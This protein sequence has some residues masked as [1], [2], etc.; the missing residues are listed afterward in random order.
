MKARQPRITLFTTSECNHC[1]QLKQWLKQ[2]RIHFR[3]LN[4]QRSARAMREFR[5]HGGRGL[6]LLLVGERAIRGFD[7]KRLTRELRKAGIDLPG[8]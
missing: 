4:L 2:H 3:E 8:L 6:P 7:P 1:R 5:H